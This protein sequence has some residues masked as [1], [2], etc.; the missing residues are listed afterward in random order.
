MGETQEMTDDRR[1]KCRFCGWTTR[2]FYTGA[3]GQTIS[4]MNAL[5]SHIDHAHPVEADEIFL[6]QD[7]PE[8]VEL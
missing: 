6:D 5:R 7:E 8:D 3:D 1:I 4:G 2:P